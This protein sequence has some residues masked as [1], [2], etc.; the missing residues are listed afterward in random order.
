M[1]SPATHHDFGPKPIPATAGIG[2]KAEHIVEVLDTRSAIGWFEVHAE[3]YMPGTGPAI[4]DLERVREHYPVSVHGVG[5]SLGGREPL[6]TD[7]LDRLKTVVDRIEPGLVSEHLAWCREGGVYLNDLLPVP[8]HSGSLQTVIDHVDQ[9]QEHLGRHILIENPSLYV[10]YKG[11]DIAEPDF[12]AEIAKRTGCG[13]LLDIN[14]VAVS[15]ANLGFD[16]RDYLDAFDLTAVAEI[17]IAGHAVRSF[18][19]RTVCIDDH[20]SP[21]SI[22]VW[23]LTGQTLAQTGPLPVLIE[24][25]NDIPPLSDLLSEARTADALMAVYTGNGGFDAHAA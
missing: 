19:G 4:T 3:N 8:Y 11:S 18:E 21:V 6:D 5:M 20:G 9:M 10:A 25:D 14:N 24:R 16:A 22:T 1:H 13:L 7:H 2:L 23:N 17:H 12:L 15:A